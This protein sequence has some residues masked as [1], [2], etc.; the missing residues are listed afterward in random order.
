MPPQACFIT[1]TANSRKEILFIKSLTPSC[2]LLETPTAPMWMAVATQISFNISI[3]RIKKFNTSTMKI[4]Q[5]TQTQ[6]K[7]NL[8]SDEWLL[9]SKGWISCDTFGKKNS[10]SR[11]QSKM[12]THFM[13]IEAKRSGKASQLVSQSIIATWCWF[14]SYWRDQRNRGKKL[15]VEREYCIFNSIRTHT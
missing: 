3:K 10:T 14:G 1:L 2:Q 12:L 6:G 13:G 15:T 9:Y 8:I 4:L 7:P 11:T 5:H